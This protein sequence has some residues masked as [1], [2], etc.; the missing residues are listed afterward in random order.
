MGWETGS[1]RPEWPWQAE[2]LREPG[3]LLDSNEEESILYLFYFKSKQFLLC[4]M[5]KR[6]HKLGRENMTHLVISSLFSWQQHWR[7]REVPNS[8]PTHTPP[9]VWGWPGVWRLLLVRLKGKQPRRG[10][11]CQDE[12]IQ[13]DTCSVPEWV[14]NKPIA[15][16]T[17]CYCQRLHIVP[18]VQPLTQNKQP[19]VLP[20]TL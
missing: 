7:S 19:L 11:A 10:N 14:N 18:Q 13:P 8:C 20:P 3:S 9:A 6:F 12:A 1:E 17:H 16:Q 15:C 4:L 5:S 2:R